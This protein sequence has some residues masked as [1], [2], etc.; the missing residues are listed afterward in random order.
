M[1]L[2]SRGWAPDRVSI[3]WVTCVA[4]AFALLQLAGVR[5]G[6]RD[7]CGVRICVCVCVGWTMM[8]WVLVLRCLP[9]TCRGVGL[10]QVEPASKKNRA[11]ARVLYTQDTPRSDQAAFFERGRARLDRC[12]HWNGSTRYVRA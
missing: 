12:I 4:G 9:V 7:V 1:S 11:N 8:D 10:G 6:W 5:V 2:P 3:A